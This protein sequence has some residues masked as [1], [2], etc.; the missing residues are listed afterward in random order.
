MNER[1]DLVVIGAGPAGEKG[2]AQA[3][4]FGKRVAIVDRREDPG[5]SAASK[6]GVPTKTLREAALYLTGFRRRDLYGLGLEL[7]R[8]TVLERM[9]A[10]TAEVVRLSVDAV[11]A[12]IERHGME[13][14]QGEAR[15]GP[16]RTVVVA[17]PEGERTLGADV[18]LVA[19]GSR[20]FHLP[21]IPF[22]DPD[23]HDSESILELHE[24]PSSLVVVGGGPVGCEYASIFLALGADVTLVDRGGRLLPAVDAEVSGCLEEVF[25]RRGMHLAFET[26]VRGVSRTSGLLSVELSDGRTLGPE[27]ILFAAGRT[28][29]TGTLGLAE[30]GVRTDERG[31]ILVDETYRTTA[32]GIYAAGDVTGPPGLASVAMEQGRVAACHAFGIPFKETVDPLPPFGVYSVPEVAMVGLTEADARAAGMDVETGRSPFLAN[33]RARIAGATE[34]LVKL[35]FDRDDR[36]L[37]GVHI[38]GE[39]ASELIHIGQAVLQAKGPIDYFI[40]A[41]FNVPTLSEAYKYAAYDG[42]QRL[43]GHQL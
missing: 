29:T 27:A 18:I 20:P 39:D 2:G 22:D 42:L 10:R 25:V 33:A 40:H 12:N 38:V 4:Y 31:R 32:E 36:R 13:L 37:L 21:G 17:T 8:D 6:T 30:A 23:V 11:R 16:D 43:S 14:V 5:G 35:V 1:F 34:G 9:R 7:T 24:I 3:A 19:T 26:D 15:L 41:T 28:G